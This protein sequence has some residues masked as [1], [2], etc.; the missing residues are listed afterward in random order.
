[1][2]DIT[3][4]LKHTIF[5]KDLFDYKKKTV[6]ALGLF[7]CPRN[8]NIKEALNELP[9]CSQDERPYK[10][11]D[12]Y[13][14]IILALRYDRTINQISEPNSINLHEKYHKFLVQKRELDK[15]IRDGIDEIVSDYCNVVEPSHFNRSDKKP[16]I[17]GRRKIEKA[18]ADYIEKKLIIIKSYYDECK[19][20]SKKIRKEQIKDKMY[21]DFNCECGYSGIYAHKNRHLKTELHLKRLINKL[22]KEKE[23]ENE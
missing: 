11:N 19:Q 21:E 4:N 6:S 9:Y 16:K 20:V 1:M 15:N 22:E 14:R 3:F 17:I 8:V 18:L 5:H 10:C 13:N 23:N 2:E 12:K 7:L